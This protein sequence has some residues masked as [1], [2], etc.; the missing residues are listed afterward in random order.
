MGTMKFNTA[1]RF[2]ENWKAMINSHVNCW[3]GN[4]TLDKMHD[5]LYGEADKMKKYMLDS[6]IKHVE[7]PI[8]FKGKMSGYLEAIFTDINRNKTKFVY[9]VFG[10]FY[11]V[12]GDSEYPRWDILPREI[13]GRKDFGDCGMTVWKDTGRFYSS[14][15]D[16]KENQNYMTFWIKDNC[17]L[18]FT[19]SGPYKNDPIVTETKCSGTEPVSSKEEFFQK[20][21]YLMD[22]YKVSLKNVVDIST[23][24]PFLKRS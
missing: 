15:S 9:R 13:Y 1:C 22:T 2:Y 20:I 21:I 4:A 6:G 3:S 24:N 12:K 8:F 23:N 5:V 16:E 18:C 19:I 11:S 14:H 7:I 10:S 17:Y